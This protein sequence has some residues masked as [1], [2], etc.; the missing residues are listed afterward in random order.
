MSEPT[1]PAKIPAQPQAQPAHKGR[2]RHIALTVPD[3]WKA[4]E[5]YMQAFGMEKVG[6]TDSSLACGVYLT[7]GVINM[8]LLRYKTDEAAGTERG[9]NYV[10][11][12]HM[13]FWVDDVATSA[14]AIDA[15]GGK[16]WMGE[17]STLGNT[18]YEVKYRDPN[19]VVFDITANGWGGASKDGSSPARS[20]KLRHENLVA[21]RSAIPD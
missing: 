5:F 19:N 2:L 6:E 4:A 8:A 16:W 14:T 13:G 1:G 20:P 11:I 12:H 10:G 17:A 15:A 9:R 21:D 3:P 18:F 7:D